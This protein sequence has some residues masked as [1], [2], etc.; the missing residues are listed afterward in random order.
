MPYFANNIDLEIELGSKNLSNTDL[1]KIVNTNSNWIIERTGIESRPICDD[2]ENVFTLS[3]S[4]IRK[5]L[6]RHDVQIDGIIAATTTATEIFPN[7][8][9]KL[10]AA[11]NI[12]GFSFD[13]SAACSGYI[14]ALHIAQ[15]MVS[16]QKDLKNILVISSDTL[17][18]CVDWGDRNTCILFGDAGTATLVQKQ[19]HDKPPLSSFIHSCHDTNRD[20]ILKNGSIHNNYGFIEMN[21]KSVFKNAVAQMTYNMTTLLEREGLTHN[22]IDAIVPHQANQRILKAV[23]QK[24]DVEQSKVF[25]CMKDIGNTSAASIPIALKKLSLTKTFKNNS[26]VLMSAFG[27][28]FTSGSLLWHI[29][30]NQNLFKII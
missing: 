4:A 6:T 3:L 17:T 9:N 18:K 19:L 11:L 30:K 27:A 16:T 5:L 20:L 23:A 15:S 26:K 14:Y 22:S 24:M 29:D 28:G 2:K 7:L 21:G 1:E 10:A 12:E 8:S 25:S 13:I